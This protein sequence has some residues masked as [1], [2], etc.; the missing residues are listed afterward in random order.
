[1]NEKYVRRTARQIVSDISQFRYVDEWRIESWM[2]GHKLERIDSVIS[3]VI[4]IGYDKTDKED[5]HIAI[6][7]ASREWKSLWQSLWSDLDSDLLHKIEE[8]QNDIDSLREF[9]R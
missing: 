8:I 7:I 9:C 2:A 5:I 1:M 4:G 6:D 3:F